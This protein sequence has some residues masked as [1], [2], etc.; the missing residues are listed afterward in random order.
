MFFANMQLVQFQAPE[1][2]AFASRARKSVPKAW[3]VSGVNRVPAWIRISNCPHGQNNAKHGE[4][5]HRHKEQ[6]D[7]EL[8]VPILGLEGKFSIARPPETGEQETK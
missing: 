8:E 6:S 5:H 2:C 3:Q 7:S 1:N 4:R